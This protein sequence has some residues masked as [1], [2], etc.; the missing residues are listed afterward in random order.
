MDQAILM[1]KVIFY[2]LLVLIT[3]TFGC[4]EYHS[5]VNRELATNVKRDTLLLD[6]RFGMTQ[7]EFFTHCWELNKEGIVK[8]G[9]TNST[10]HFQIEKFGKKYDVNFYPVFYE[11]RIV[12][13]PVE[14]SYTVFSPWNSDYSL[15]LLFEE[16]M[17]IYRSDYGDD[18]LKIESKERIAY[19]RVDGNRRIS[20]FN[21]INRNNVTALYFDLSSEKNSEK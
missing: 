11:G 2:S 1:L 12:G 5:L 17:N 3:L 19:V 15:D 10:V 16:I 20:I 8:E 18:F 13:L 6:L 4:N 7:R 9:A 21:N 14:Y